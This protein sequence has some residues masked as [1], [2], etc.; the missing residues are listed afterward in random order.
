MPVINS[1][2]AFIAEDNGPE[3]EGACAMFHDRVWLPLIAADEKRLESLR[4][5]AIELAKY[6]GKLIHLVRFTTRVEMEIINPD[7]SITKS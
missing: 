5:I 2:W 7:G 3:D 6:V 4:P 1:V